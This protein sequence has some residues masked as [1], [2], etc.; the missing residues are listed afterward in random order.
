[1]SSLAV[2]GASGM[3]G[4]TIIKMIEKYNIE[5]DDIDLYASARSAGKEVTVNG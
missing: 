1:M 5:Y 3:V 2:I 4:E